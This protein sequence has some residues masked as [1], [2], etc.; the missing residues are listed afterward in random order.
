MKV[1][2]IAAKTYTNLI[3]RKKLESFIMTLN[4]KIYY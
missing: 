3:Y 2:K 1:S 4:Q